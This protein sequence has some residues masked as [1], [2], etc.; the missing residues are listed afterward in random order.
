MIQQKEKEMERSTLSVKEEKAVM[1][2]M[3][4]LKDDARKTTEWQVEMDELRNKRS[5][6]GDELRRQSELLDQQRS[7][8]W[9]EQS[10]Q[11]LN[12]PL[13]ELTETKLPVDEE[14]QEL[15]MTPTWK[16]KFTEVGVVAKTERGTKKTVV[17]AGT[18]SGVEVA[19]T[20]I[21]AIGP[22]AVLRKPLDEEQQG[23]LIGR[24]GATIAQLQKD[25]GCSLDI[26]KGKGEL[27]IAGPSD[28]VAQAEVLID[29][30]LTSQASPPAA[31]PSRPIPDAPPAF[32]RTAVCVGAALGR[33]RS[34]T[35]FLTLPHSPSR[36][37]PSSPSCRTPVPLLRYKP[38][39]PATLPHA[40]PR[41]QH[42]ANCP[43]N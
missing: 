19:K 28:L 31:H 9:R 20:M 34:A 43:A 6:C 11:K 16:A 21:Q 5:A 29:E 40:R 35:L 8:Q 2:E 10:S 27:A 14:T 32:S 18:A 3:K 4:K 42:H 33:P 1:A 17:L 7:T 38:R 13:E 22:V 25:T 39:E 37:H 26:R 24:K 12:V 41:P 15:L 30:L 23:L 36:P